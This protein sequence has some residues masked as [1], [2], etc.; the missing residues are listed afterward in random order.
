MTRRIKREFADAFKHQ[1]VQLYNSGKPRSEIA[2]ECDLTSSALSNWI[3][4]INATG[5]TKES[6]NRSPEAT[7]LLKLPKKTIS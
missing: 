1:M 3:R 2:R 5:S 4:R 7:K 6:D